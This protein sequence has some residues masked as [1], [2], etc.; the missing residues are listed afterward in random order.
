MKYW[1]LPNIKNRISEGSIPA[2]FNTQV[3]EIRPT[4][5]VL[6][7]PEGLLEIENDFVLAMTGYSPDYDLLERLGVP[8]RQEDQRDQI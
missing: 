1:I 5:V 2:Y 4:S 7:T 3:K 6:E 8:I